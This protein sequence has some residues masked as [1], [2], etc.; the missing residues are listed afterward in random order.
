MFLFYKIVGICLQS[1]IYSV[2]FHFFSY[3]LKT[4][5]VLFISG[6]L[7]LADK[8]HRRAPKLSVM[9]E[10]TSQKVP[11]PFTG[12]DLLK[13]PASDNS[14]ENPLLGLFSL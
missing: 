10:A 6:K 7:V 1:S 9:G 8:V 2:C 4:C 11:C 5:Q 13:Q 12:Q 3:P 14:I